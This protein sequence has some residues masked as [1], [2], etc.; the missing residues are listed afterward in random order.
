MG[1]VFVFH[2]SILLERLVARGDGRDI[3]ILVHHEL[4]FGGQGYIAA[5][6]SPPAWQI[7]LF[8]RGSVRVWET[9]AASYCHHGSAVVDPEQRL[10]TYP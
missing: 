9:L 2:T 10:S 4:A 5:N 8:Y 6:Y 1:F 3:F 7:K